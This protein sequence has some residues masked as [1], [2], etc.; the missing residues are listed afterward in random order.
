VRGKHLISR[1]KE[2]LSLFSQIAKGLGYNGPPRFAGVRLS[3]PDE[4]SAWGIAYEIA[5][6]EYD[7][8]GLEPTPGDLVVDIG[9]NIGLFAL[10]A[11]R[12]GASVVAY[13]AAESTVAHLRANTQGHPSITPIWA[14]V[15][16]TKTENTVRLYLHDERSTRHT[17]LGREIG[18]GE[19]LG[20]YTDVPAIAIADVLSEPCD[21]LKIDCEGGEFEIFSE[22]S[23][24]TLR[25]ARRIILEFHRT[26]GD[27]AVLLE[28]LQ[29]AGFAAEILEGTAATEEFGVIGACRLD[30]P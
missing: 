1:S 27:P 5:A 22:I 9:A 17:L 19:L 29:T 24:A 7:F 11:A 6:G 3:A 10:W 21:L 26:I 4:V 18:S 30:N 20:R 12:R 8:A 23:I 28:R 2:G 13:E 14:A 15:V 25:K 16:G